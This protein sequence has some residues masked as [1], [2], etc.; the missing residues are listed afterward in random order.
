VSEPLLLEGVFRELCCE[1]LALSVRDYLDVLSALL[2]GYGGGSKAALVQL[3]QS[4]WAR[5]EDEDQ[6]IQAVFERVTRVGPEERPVIEQARAALNAAAGTVALLDTPENHGVETDT[7]TNARVRVQFSGAGEQG[8][9]LPQA[10]VGA[11]DEAF[12]LSGRPL[13]SERAMSIAWRRFNRPARSGPRTEIDIEATVRAQARSQVLAEP[14]LLPARVNRAR[15]VVA[16]DVSASM[17][18]WRRYI[19]SFERALVHGRLA[20]A[21]VFYFDNVPDELWRRRPLDGRVDLRR[22]LAATECSALLIV[23]DA[24]AA[25]ASRRASRAQ[26]TVRFFDA[27]MS[28][29]RPIVWLNPT[30]RK[31]WVGTTAELIAKARGVASFSVDPSDFTRAIDALRGRG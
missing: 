12:L 22:E 8:L 10:V 16:I 17:V 26:E 31:R 6:L 25:R 5:S 20:S 19:E 3:C 29:W 2:A 24:G 4:L 11:R 23:S 1:G 13:I 7:G 28:R 15:V 9:P 18:A 27:V 14:V 21:E 30:P